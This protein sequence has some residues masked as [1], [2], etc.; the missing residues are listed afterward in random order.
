MY[1]NNKLK[2]QYL[3]QRLLLRFLHVASQLT[4]KERTRKIVKDKKKIHSALV[5]WNNGLVNQKRLPLL[6]EKS[7][8][9]LIVLV[10]PAARQN[11]G[12]FENL[13]LIVLLGFSQCLTKER[14]IMVLP[15]HLGQFFGQGVL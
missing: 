14:F 10:G 12:R 5:N 4:D 8:A 2:A 3:D 15:M 9:I 11:T 6:C 7:G 13:L 1:D